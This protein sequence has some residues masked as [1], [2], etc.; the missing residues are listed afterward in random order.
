MVRTEENVPFEVGWTPKV[1]AMNP[2][3]ETSNGEGNLRGPPGFL[4]VPLQL[5]EVDI[6]AVRGRDEA[7]KKK[8]SIYGGGGWQY[9]L[10]FGKSWKIRKENI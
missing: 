3:E 5:L 10:Y 4:V 9:S 1:A 6:F 8:D 2:S 7:E